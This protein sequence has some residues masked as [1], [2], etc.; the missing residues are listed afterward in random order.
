MPEFRIINK[1]R[2]PIA[3]A[4]NDNLDYY[5]WEHRATM[6]QGLREFMVFVDQGDAVL[7]TMPQAYIEEITGGNLVEIKDDSLWQAA[8]GFA[9][10]NRLLV[11]MPP[12]FKK[13]I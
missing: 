6:V 8:M 1:K 4:N 10:E 3:M 13:A 7:K 2:F 12:I 5:R 11:I 9:M